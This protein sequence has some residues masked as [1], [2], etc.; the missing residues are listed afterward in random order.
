MLALASFLDATA[1][2]IGATGASNCERCERDDWDWLMV[3]ITMVVEVAETI[4]VQQRARCICGCKA[5]ID[6]N[7]RYQ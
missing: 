2:K 3:M 5:Q 4:W 7:R 6:R 1:W